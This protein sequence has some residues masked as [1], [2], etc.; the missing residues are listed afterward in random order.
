MA[1]AVVTESDLDL[2]QTRN[3]APEG[4]SFLAQ[5]ATR[6]N[7]QLAA[8]TDRAA[9]Q[10]RLAGAGHIV[11]RSSPPPIYIAQGGLRQAPGRA[12]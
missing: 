1:V 7:G 3:E 10:G 8:H 11:S 5:G 4:A 12:A 2:T 9:A 6:P